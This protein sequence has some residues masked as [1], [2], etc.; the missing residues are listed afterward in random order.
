M[1]IDRR[2]R[3]NTNEDVH[4]RLP[5]PFRKRTTQV[6]KKSRKKALAADSNKAKGNLVEEIAALLH[7]GSGVTIERN[8]K[9]PVHPNSKRT[10]EVDVL[11]TGMLAGYP[12]R[13]AIECKNYGKPIGVE[14]IGVFKSKLEHIGIPPQHGIYISAS[15]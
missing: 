4:S 3:L 9:V 14:L 12:L 2:I 8:A 7:E 13:I 6:V 1:N 11:V 10:R 5:Y 15:D